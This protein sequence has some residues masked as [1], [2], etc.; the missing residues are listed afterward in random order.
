V[1]RRAV[2][3]DPA[4]A[5]ERHRRAGKRRLHNRTTAYDPINDYVWVTDGT[6][7]A[8]GLRYFDLTAGEWRMHSKGGPS[9]QSAVI[10][11]PA[12]KRFVAFG[13][14]NAAILERADAGAVASRCRL[15]IVPMKTGPRF[16]SDT[17][18]MT[19][20]R[21]VRREAPRMVRRY[22]WTLWAL[23]LAPF[24]WEQVATPVR[25]RPHGRST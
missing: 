9:Y 21:S 10:F 17:Q 23:T 3:L 24:A 7:G 8:S 12:G 20:Q 11:D 19:A 2:R 4:R 14:W 22:G 1:D 6:G 15:G 18:K 16:I 25:R 5:L 13:E